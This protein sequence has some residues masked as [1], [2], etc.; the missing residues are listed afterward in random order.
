MEV[1]FDNDLIT[2]LNEIESKCDEDRP[3]NIPLTDYYADYVAI[4]D[5]KGNLL[6]I[7]T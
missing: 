7:Y 3:S 4:P 6:V 1:T 2:K 5:Y